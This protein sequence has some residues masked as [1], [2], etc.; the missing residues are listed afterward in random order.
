MCP[1]VLDPQ[2]AGVR[3]IKLA[4][5]TLLKVEWHTIPHRR[6]RIWFRISAGR[7]RATS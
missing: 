3:V 2:D 4:A 5:W 6:S 1:G 7:V